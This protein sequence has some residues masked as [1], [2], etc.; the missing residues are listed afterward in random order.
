MGQFKTLFQQ[1]IEQAEEFRE[2][3]DEGIDWVRKW[4]TLRR[5]ERQTANIQHRF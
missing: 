1:S 4:V 5:K 2:N 3:T